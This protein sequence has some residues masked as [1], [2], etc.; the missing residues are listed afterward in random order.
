MKSTYWPLRADALAN[1]QF[2]P[3]HHFSAIP[4]EAKGSL[5]AQQSMA[6][7]REGKETKLSSNEKIIGKIAPA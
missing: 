1:L 4:A 5:L 7:T 6:K 2:T 3:P